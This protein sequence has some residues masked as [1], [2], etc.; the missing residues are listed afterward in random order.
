MWHNFVL[1]VVALT[2][3]FLMPVFLFPVYSTGNGAL[4]T[5]VV[6]VGAW[7]ALIQPRAVLRTSVCVTT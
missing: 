2:F 3:L 7:V 1:C 6:P 4:V 5:A